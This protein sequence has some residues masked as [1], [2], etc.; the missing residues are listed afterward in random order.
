MQT[1]QTRKSPEKAWFRS[2]DLK[3]LC[4]LDRFLELHCLVASLAPLG[5]RVGLSGR[6]RS[7]SRWP[8][9]VAPNHSV[10][11]G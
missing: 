11:V 10:A 4:A 8:A 1:L 6:P 9:T 7:E 5:K 3:S 2:V